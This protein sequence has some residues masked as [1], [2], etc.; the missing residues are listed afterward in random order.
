LGRDLII[1]FR[2]MR[3]D[4]R[5]AIVDDRRHREQRRIELFVYWGGAIAMVPWIVFLFTT[6]P[7]HVLGLHI[8]VLRAGVAAILI[9]GLASTAILSRL[10]ASITEILA[11]ATASTSLATAWF[12]LVGA[13]HRRASSAVVITVLVLVPTIC[14]TGLIAWR[15]LLSRG[16]RWSVPRWAPVACLVILAIGVVLFA[17]SHEAAQDTLFFRRMRIA[18]TGL[19]IFELIGLVATGYAIK[20][21]SPLVALCATFTGSIL[22]CDAW[23]NVVSTTGRTQ[24]SAIAMAFVEIPLATYSIYLAVREVR[25]WKRKDRA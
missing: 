25:R 4:F 20:V 22:F 21:R 16:A 2:S 6:Q 9:A 1:D 12:V 14:V 19:D 5:K 11:M 10:Q 15:V 17:R 13:S 3:I 23:Y 7:S 24:Q 18:W 8:T